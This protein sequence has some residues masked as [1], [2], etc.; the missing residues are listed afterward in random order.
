MLQPAKRA[1]ATASMERNSRPTLGHR[2]EPSCQPNKTWLGW[3][4][5][6][7]APARAGNPEII[8]GQEVV[9]SSRGP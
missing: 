4:T 9:A 8:M 2:T 6:R 7:S 3:T 5:G 1:G